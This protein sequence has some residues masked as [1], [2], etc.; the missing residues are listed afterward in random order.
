MRHMT[1]DL[2]APKPGPALLALA[3]QRVT[4]LPEH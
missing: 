1:G 4:E 3:P 2:V